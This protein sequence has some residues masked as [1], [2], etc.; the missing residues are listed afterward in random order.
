VPH[1]AGRSDAFSV[2]PKLST[3]LRLRGCVVDTPAESTVQM[4]STSSTVRR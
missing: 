4:C 3:E 1:G 2:E